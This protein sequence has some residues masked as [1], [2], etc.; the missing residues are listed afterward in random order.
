MMVGCYPCVRKDCM[1]FVRQFGQPEFT[2]EETE[3][4]NLLQKKLLMYHDISEVKHIGALIV[5]ME[6]MKVD[7]LKTEQWTKILGKLGCLSPLMGDVVYSKYQKLLKS[8]KNNETSNPAAAQVSSLVAL[9]SKPL[10]KRRVKVENNLF[11]ALAEEDLAA[12]QP[13]S[14]PAGDVKMEDADD[15]A[16]DEAAIEEA[17]KKSLIGDFSPPVGGPSSSSSGAG[18]FIQK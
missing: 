12:F 5:T 4:K 10:K 13:K 6:E 16:A 9:V 14:V 17:K 18:L 15:D 3:F 1:I 2:K 8:I 11:G 7:D